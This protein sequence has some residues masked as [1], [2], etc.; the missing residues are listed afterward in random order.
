[1]K[2]NIKRDFSGILYRLR[3]NGVG[4]I[5][6]FYHTNI[7][8]D[9][10][11]SENGNSTEFDEIWEIHFSDGVNYLG[12]LEV[13]WAPNLNF[14]ISGE[15]SK[16]LNFYLIEYSSEQTDG[17]TIEFFFSKKKLLTTRGKCIIE[18]LS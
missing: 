11:F 16:C 6:C 1:M 13:H 15:D 2:N 14:A 18:M 4:F 5:E 17:E 3:A 9:E 12:T 7:E 10:L 8:T